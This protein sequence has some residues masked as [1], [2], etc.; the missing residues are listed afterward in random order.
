MFAPIGAYFSWYAGWSQR[1]AHRCRRGQIVAW[2]S[3]L[4]HNDN[5]QQPERD[6]FRFGDQAEMIK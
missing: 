4:E 1:A 3:C 5:C 6:R 2:R